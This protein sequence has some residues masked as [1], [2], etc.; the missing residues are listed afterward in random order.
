MLLRSV[1]TMVVNNV[2]DRKIYKMYAKTY[3][4]LFNK[5]QLVNFDDDVLQIC[6]IN[7]ILAKSSQLC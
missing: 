5:G 1:G 3:I 4:K 6:V 7:I 2:D